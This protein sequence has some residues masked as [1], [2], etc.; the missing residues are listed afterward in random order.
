MEP[1]PVLLVTC[2]EPLNRDTLTKIPC[3]SP[4]GRLLPRSS[5]LPPVGDDQVAP[6]RGVAE[7]HAVDSGG[8]PVRPLTTTLPSIVLRPNVVKLPMV[9]LL[10]TLP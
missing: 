3:R 10:S 8:C 9:G 1:P 2:S 5:V 4:L 7:V 6:D